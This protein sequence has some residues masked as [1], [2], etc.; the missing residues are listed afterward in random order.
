M[1]FSKLNN[2]ILRFSQ[3]TNERE[4]PIVLIRFSISAASLPGS[5]VPASHAELL[6]EDR[7]GRGVRDECLGQRLRAERAE[8]SI[9]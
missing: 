2:A 9:A 3:S 1:G 7:I 8:L 6:A 4:R 5:S